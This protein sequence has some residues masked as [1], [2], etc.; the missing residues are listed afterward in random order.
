LARL[1]FL[2]LPLGSKSLSDTPRV[3]CCDLIEDGV[4]S[5][6]LLEGKR[7]LRREL[8][9]LSIKQSEDFAELVG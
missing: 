9:N 7:F 4:I 2:F 1:G 3:K 8:V 6:C 5:G